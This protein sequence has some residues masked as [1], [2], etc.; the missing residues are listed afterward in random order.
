MI[1]RELAVKLGFAMDEASAAAADARIAKYENELGG[2]GRFIEAGLVLPIQHF[3]LKS[4][5]AFVGAQKEVARY[6]ALLGGSAEKAAQMH[7]EVEKFAATNPFSLDDVQATAE[8][9]LKLGLSQERVTQT[10]ETLK[11]TSSATG[12]GMNELAQAYGRV[13]MTNRL[14]MRGVRSF[15]GAAGSLM[16]ALSATTGMNRNVLVATLRSGLLTA[17]QLETALRWLDTH[18]FAGATERQAETLDGRMVRLGNNFKILKE[19]VGG[20]IVGVFQIDKVLGKL[21]DIIGWLTKKFTELSPQAQRAILIL[22]AIIPIVWQ[23]FVLG[24]KIVAFFR[25]LQAQLWTTI[26][27]VMAISAA[28]YLL[29]DDFMAWSQGRKSVLG[30]IFGA[31]DEFGKKATAAIRGIRDNG[32]EYLRDGLKKLGFFNNADV[33]VGNFIGGTIGAL[34]GQSFKED[35]PLFKIYGKKNKELDHHRASG[36]A[37][38]SANP[39]AFGGAGGAAGSTVVNVNVGGLVSADDADKFGRAIA[40]HVEKAVNKAQVESHKQAFYTYSK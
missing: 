30:T 27:P 12:V 33:A 15:G 1:I 17:Q 3:A 6:T 34:W 7:E 39:L 21:A 11:N 9:L 29:F 5:E 22:G 26:A 23:L 18:R 19:R 36:L 4:I 25:L 24:P 38:P 28:L 37:M 31:F 16:Q 40:P 8:G 32:I 10:M 20:A 13:Q 14:D 35:D 2:L